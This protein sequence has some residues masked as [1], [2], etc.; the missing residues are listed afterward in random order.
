MQDGYPTIVG[1][2]GAGA[3]FLESYTQRQSVNCIH[4]NN[5]VDTVTRWR[6]GALNCFSLLV[7]KGETIISAADKELLRSLF[8]RSPLIVV[9][10]GLG[11]S[12]NSYLSCI[13]ELLGHQMHNALFVAYVPFAFEKS[14]RAKAWSLMESSGLPLVPVD[15]QGLLERN[16]SEKL[17]LDEVF[18]KVHRI[19]SSVIDEIFL[20]VHPDS[21]GC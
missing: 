5:D 19:T 9:V 14:R 4:I 17:S 15:L 8:R 12:C 1:L 2:G 6:D 11:G 18:E 21:V 3:G 16:S 20:S 10:V 13:S 7:D